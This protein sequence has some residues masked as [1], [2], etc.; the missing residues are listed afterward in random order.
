MCA[1]PGKGYE[2]AGVYINVSQALLRQSK[3][4]VR[5]DATGKKTIKTEYQ[6]TR[7]KS[8]ASGRTSSNKSAPRTYIVASANDGK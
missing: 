1:G 8:P 5:Q 7:S 6:I 2:G 3:A 4:G